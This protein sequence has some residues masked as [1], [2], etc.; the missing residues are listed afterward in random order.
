M[1][2]WVWEAR[3]YRIMAMYQRDHAAAAAELDKAEAILAEKKDAV[4]KAD[5]DE[6][7]A[8]ILRV[9]VEHAIAHNDL[10]GAQKFLAD[11]ETMANSGSF[12]IQRTYSGA[13][14]TLLL[15]RKKYRDAAAQLEQDFTNPISMKLLVV[16]Y[17]KS[18]TKAQAEEWRQRLLDWKIPTVEEALVVF[19]Y[20]AQQEAVAA[21]K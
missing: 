14:G 3:A 19:A 6:E 5:L 18:N 10:A 2:Q 15:A 13:E 12:T 1:G 20:R 17:Q 11:L 7:R 21:K 4:A 16:A 8:R 9:R